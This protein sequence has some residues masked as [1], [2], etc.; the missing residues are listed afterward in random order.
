M[1]T[2]VAITTKHNPDGRDFAADPFAGRPRG[3]GNGSWQVWYR[4]LCR[5]IGREVTFAGY[6]SGPSFGPNRLQLGP[7]IRK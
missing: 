6:F 7:R 2:Y 1:K 3:P 5:V 4:Y